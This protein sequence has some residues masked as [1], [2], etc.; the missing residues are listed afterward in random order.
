VLGLRKGDSGSWVVD[1]TS[2][3][4]YGHVIA[5][6]QGY[7]FIRPTKD[8][9]REIK[10][11]FKADVV[12]LPTP[13]D[14]LAE[15]SKL[16]SERSQP[17]QADDFAKQSIAADALL[18]SFQSSSANIIQE[19]LREKHSIDE[20]VLCRILQATGSDVIG[21]LRKSEVWDAAR[22]GSFGEKETSVQV[23]KSLS[24]EAK[25]PINLGVL[26][27]NGYESGGPSNDDGKFLLE[28]CVIRRR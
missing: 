7:A 8:V 3:V 20:A 26:N 28:K 2:G 19:V 13:F 4:L 23:L 11:T 1:P 27:P 9:F 21:A 25:I 6:S 22:S 14:L 18:H 5:I 24:Q 17:N 10:D 16:G 15:L 12:Q